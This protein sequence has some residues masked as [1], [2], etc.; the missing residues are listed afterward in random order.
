GRGA[1]R[2]RLLGDI[3]RRYRESA[4]VS[5]VETAHLLSAAIE[6]SSRDG[7]LQPDALRPLFQALYAH[8]FKADI[9]GVSK[10]RVELR[11]LVVDRAGRV[12]FDSLGRNEGHDFSRWNDVRLALT[13]EYGA[14]PTPG[15]EGERR[16]SVLDGEVS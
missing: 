5:L 9:Y 2:Y 16:T 6:Q 14:R 13:G 7:S 8:Q 15:V 1:G 11:A 10:T 4:E 12:V 3:D